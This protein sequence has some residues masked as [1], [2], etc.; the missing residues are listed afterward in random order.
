VG[1]P[2]SATATGTVTGTFTPT[3]FGIVHFDRPFVQG[4]IT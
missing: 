4:N 3:G 1:T 2:V